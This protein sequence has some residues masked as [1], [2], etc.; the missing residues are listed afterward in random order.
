[1]LL[2]LKIFQIND[3]LPYLLFKQCI[4]GALLSIIGSRRLF[5]SLSLAFIVLGL[6]LVLIIDKGEVVL[7][8]NEIHTPA[9]NQFFKTVTLFGEWIGGFV[10]GSLI[11][12]FAKRKFL[13]IYLVAVFL[14]SLTAQV[15]KREVYPD[16]KRPSAHLESLNDI[17][18]YER[19]VD[20]T[21][22]SGHTTAAF[23]FATVLALAFASRRMQLISFSLAFLV[24]L[25]RIYL[26]Q[27]FL[28]DVAAGAVLGL[29][30]TTL[31]AF[32]MLPRLQVKDS[33]NQTLFKIS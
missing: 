16:E 23:T 17:R 11:L 4:F 3:F 8:F 5:F 2:V 15:L 24:G 6:L 12:L 20:Y 7:L 13:A 26:G 31:T 19:H 10:L 9:L 30:I 1:M 18:D 29:I 27:H 25:S 22:P 33:W 32:V 14:S 21:F 28:H